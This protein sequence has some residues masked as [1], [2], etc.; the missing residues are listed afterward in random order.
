MRSPVALGA[1][2]ALA[3]VMTR[4]EKALPERGS[5]SEQLYVARC[6]SCHRAFDPSSMTAAMWQI[7][8]GAMRDKI[9]K[10]GQPPLTAQEEH[11]ILDYLE[12]NAGK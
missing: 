11:Q 7:Q 9:I 8:V 1:V 6:G 10:A 3:L 2:L 4:C 12:R 5:P